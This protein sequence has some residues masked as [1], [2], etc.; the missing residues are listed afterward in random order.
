MKWKL[1]PVEPTMEMVGE[2]KKC[3]RCETYLPHESFSKSSS[4]KDGMQRW[5]KT[6]M[7]AEYHKNRESIRARQ[8]EQWREYSANN[9]ELLAER[10]RQYRLGNSAKINQTKREYARSNRPKID[11][12]N[13][14]RLE[15]LSGR[16]IKQPCEICGDT[17][18]DAHHDDYSKQLDV[19][20]LCRIHHAQWHAIHGEARNG[21]TITR[22]RAI[23]REILGEIEK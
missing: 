23:E 22:C 4:C 6:C 13:A 19:R 7:S 17:K 2:M 8:S 14:V 10:N 15:I 5:C 1:V 18:A 20:W 21:K 16:M 12:K 3:K 11:A 9:R